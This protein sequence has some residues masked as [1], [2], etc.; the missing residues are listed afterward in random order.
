MNTTG[1]MGVAVGYAASLCRKY[2]TNPRGIYLNHIEELKK[3]IYETGAV[4]V[5]K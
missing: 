3:L 2:K 4:S 1:Q 5:M